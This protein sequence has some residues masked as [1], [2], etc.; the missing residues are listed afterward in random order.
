MA[1]KIYQSQIQAKIDRLQRER[2]QVL[3]HL[4][5]VE[6]KIQTLNNALKVMEAEALTD[7]YDT[8]LY[9]Y[10]IYHHR[11]N[12]KLRQMVLAVLKTQ[13][14]H[15]F[16]VNELTELVLLK[17]GQDPIVRPKHTVSVRGALKHWLTKGVVE[18]LEMGATDVKWRLKQK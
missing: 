15:Y 2:R 16:T 1:Q 7:E 11:F 14:D 6:D 8:E 9:S 3:E 10:R 5:L 13:P 4:A 12:G 17:D 18:R